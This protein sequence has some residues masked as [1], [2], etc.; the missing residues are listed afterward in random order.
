V[1]RSIRAPRAELPVAVIGAGPVGLA[2]AA[3][4]LERGLEPLVLEAGEEPGAGIRAWSHVRTFSPWRYNVDSAAERLLR[5]RGWRRPQP[6]EHPTGA[7][8]R[9]KYLFPLAET[10]ELAGRIRPN[11]RVHAVARLQHDK[12]KNAGR[13]VAPFELLVNGRGRPERLL[14]CAVIDASGTV[15]NPNPLGAS[16]IPA[17]GEPELAG[18]I[19]YGVPDLLGRDRSRY[20]GRRVLVVGSGH[21]AMNVLLDLIRLRD[22]NRA[23]SI[24]WAIRRSQIHDLYGGGARDAL[25]ARAALGERVRQ[26]V[27]AGSLEF[28][29]AV[30]IEELREAPDGIVVHHAG[31]RIGPL[32]EV[33]AA[34]GF[35]P[36]LAPLRELRL[37]LDPALEAPV[38]LAPLIDPNVHSCG[39]VPPHG[40]RELAHPE[41]GFFIAGTKSYGRAPTFLMLT[42]YE[43]VR[44]IAAALAGDMEAAGRVELVLPPTGVCKAPNGHPGTCCAPAEEVTTVAIRCC[45]APSA[46]EA[47]SGCCLA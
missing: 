8:L 4:L 46:S 12:M 27:D 23:T 40:A 3:H 34:T 45:A 37:A 36:S 26:L 13:D 21:S 14:A 31:G 29:T 47:E 6:D 35:R 11:A 32:D 39:T 43:Q 20:A 18:R 33:I 41:G 42:G 1:T 7:E 16:G 24:L 9:S 38:A 28:V 5:R 17:L 22:D 30:A 25:S 15:E 44:S 19:A 2:A 10:P